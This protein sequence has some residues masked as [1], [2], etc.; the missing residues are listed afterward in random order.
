MARGVE[1]GSL[2]REE[3]KVDPERKAKVVGKGGNRNVQQ[4]RIPMP[5][6][7]RGIMGMM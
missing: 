6:L 7:W 4:Q 3:G 5:V 2:V 1:G